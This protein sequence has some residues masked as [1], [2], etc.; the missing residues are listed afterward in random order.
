MSDLANSEFQ[1]AIQY[2]DSAMELLKEKS[3]PPYPQFYELLYTYST[4]VNPQLNSRI[5]TV[6]TAPQD[7]ESKI[8]LSERLYNEFI[9]SNDV[10]ERLNTVS[11]EIYNRI[12]AVRGVVN[13]AAAN[14][15]SYTGSLAKANTT[16]DSEID[17]DTLKALTAHL[18]RETK[19]M[20]ANNRALEGRLESSKSDIAALQ[21][22]L[23][24]VRRES[25]LDPLTKIYNRK[26][27]DR[28]LEQAIVNAQQGDEPLSLILFDIDH[29]KRFNDEYGHQTGD[30]VLRLVALTLKSTIKAKDKA[31]RYGGE[32]FAA[33]LPNTNLNGAILVAD[34]VR[35]AIQAKE[36]LRRSTNE[37]LGR[38]TASF[39]VAFCGP[40]DNA[41]SLV[42]RADRCLYAAKR[43]GRNRVVD[44]K[45][46]LLHAKTTA[47]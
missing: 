1:R 24:E 12:E 27:F 32:E 15:K 34:T 10:E 28:G 13:T 17:K 30:Q 18:V 3:I 35:K 25:Q 41:M 29:F 8:D 43:C 36:L 19:K 11:E 47:A 14:A 46:P 7:A 9:K 5:R 39:G 31:V 33:I 42:E 4:G 2:A 37:K 44:E 6:L 26:F 16:L 40:E 23:E 38:V 21:R 45:N 20:Q 22:D